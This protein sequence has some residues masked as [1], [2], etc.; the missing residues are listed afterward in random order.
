MG[1]MHKLISFGGSP[2][3][4][5]PHIRALVFAVVCAAYPIAKIFRFDYDCRKMSA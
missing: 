3:P 5:L 2:L 4:V 1:A